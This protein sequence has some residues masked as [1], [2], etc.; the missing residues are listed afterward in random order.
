MTDEKNLDR[1]DRAKQLAI[2]V[3]GLSLL[4]ELLHESDSLMGRWEDVDPSTSSLD[5][6]VKIAELHSSV[7]RV[8]DSWNAGTDLSEISFIDPTTG[9]AVEEGRGVPVGT[10]VNLV[11]VVFEC[12]RLLRM[13]G[14]DAGKT[15]AS[16]LLA[17]NA[18]A[19]DHDEEVLV[20]DETFA[21]PEETK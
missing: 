5:V 7:S 2:L 15:V 6:G 10:P 18:Y 17:S 21:G 14:L 19:S 8:F 3:P 9:N 20:G 16:V 13:M 12:L 4:M 1:H 11:E